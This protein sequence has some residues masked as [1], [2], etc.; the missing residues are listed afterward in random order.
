MSL[1]ASVNRQLT[2][3]TYTISDGN[4]GTDTATV[5]VLISGANDDSTL[6]NLAGDV[7]NYTEGDGA[8]VIEQGANALVS[9]I[10]SADFDGGDLNVFFFSGSDAAEDVCPSATKEPAGAKS[11]LVVAT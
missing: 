8:Q 5:T 4:G 11:V 3:F 10:D 2:P 7:L 9:D 6:T 1:W